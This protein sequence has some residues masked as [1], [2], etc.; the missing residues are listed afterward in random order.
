MKQTLRDH[1]WIIADTQQGMRQLFHN[2]YDLGRRFN[3]VVVD[4][5][6]KAFY[7]ESVYLST[8]IK[9]LETSG[10]LSAYSRVRE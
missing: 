3:I 2:I 4:G 6:Y 5:I 8:V 9:N 7:P 10:P 1:H